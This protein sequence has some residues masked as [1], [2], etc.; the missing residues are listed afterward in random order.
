VWI[1]RALES[2]VRV[3]ELTRRTAVEAGAIQRD[4]LADPLD[5]LLVAT[6]RGLEAIFVT[7]DHR[8]LNYAAASSAC[9]LYDA[10]R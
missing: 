9:R 4:A 7:A 3:A 1:D 2:G 6:T 8:I 10:R 5:R